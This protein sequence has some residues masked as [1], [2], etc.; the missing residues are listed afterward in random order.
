MS[1]KKP[2]EPYYTE[3]DRRNTCDV[4]YP[5]CGECPFLEHCKRLF[6]KKEAKG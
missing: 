1:N 6:K 3:E 2:D 5:D 4:V